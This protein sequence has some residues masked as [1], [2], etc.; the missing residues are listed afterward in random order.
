MSGGKLTMH[1]S[2]V[3]RTRIWWAL[4][5]VVFALALAAEPVGANDEHNVPS[6]TPVENAHEASEELRE[7]L[8]R[9]LEGLVYEFDFFRALAAL[10][11][12]EISAGQRAL[13]YQRY[14][15]GLHTYGLVPRDERVC[16]GTLA[17]PVDAEIGALGEAPE[18]RAGE[19]RLLPTDP[20]YPVRGTPRLVGPRGWDP[21]GRPPRDDP[22]SG[23]RS[24]YRGGT[25]TGGVGRGGGRRGN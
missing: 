19:Y 2:A 11:G 23:S 22:N 14:I 8:A 5:V 9:S 7:E 16:I 15:A 4:S 17:P 21:D 6:E 18:V 3:V 20:C 24:I 12:S 10:P 1:F 13:S 25:E